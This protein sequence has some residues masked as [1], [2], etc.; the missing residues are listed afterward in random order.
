M[1][2][3]IW[4]HIFRIV[5]IY[6]ELKMKRTCKPHLGLG[7]LKQILW[8]QGPLHW[9]HHRRGSHQNLRRGGTSSVSVG[10]SPRPMGGRASTWPGSESPPGFVHP[11]HSVMERVVCDCAETR[12][13]RSRGKTHCCHH[14]HGP[15]VC[16]YSSQKAKPQRKGRKR[17][18]WGP[19]ANINHLPNKTG[20]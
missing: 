18:D 13:L 2:H 17:V 9:E 7:N 16:R 15:E 19:S 12:V 3:R 8:G 11:R 4:W 1:N 10:A 14:D 6:K 20:E 5:A